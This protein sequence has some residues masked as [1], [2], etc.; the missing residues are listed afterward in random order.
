MIK[1]KLA[2]IVSLILMISGGFIA[3]DLVKAP[4]L[5][6]KGLIVFLTSLLV[7]VI[8]RDGLSKEDTSLLKLIYIL[9]ILADLSL[10][11][12]KKAYTG[13]IIFFF[14][15]CFLIYRNYRCIYRRYIIR[16]ILDKYNILFVLMLSI[17][18]GLY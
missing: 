2:I 4:S 12:F 14:A 15:Q 5:V 7:F 13:I 17:M 10:I 1:N 9:I 18:L 3:L 16:E 6:L 11:L 8:N